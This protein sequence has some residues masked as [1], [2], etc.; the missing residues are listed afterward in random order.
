ML[1][2]EGSYPFGNGETELFNYQQKVNVLDNARV[3]ERLKTDDFRKLGNFK[4]M[5][6]TLG[7]PNTNTNF[8][9]AL[10]SCKKPAVKH[11]LEKPVI[12]NFVNFSTI[13]CSRL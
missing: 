10:E 9:V 4:K 13:F 1:G 5:A 12:F 3:T 11:S 6:E 2:I 7:F 8:T